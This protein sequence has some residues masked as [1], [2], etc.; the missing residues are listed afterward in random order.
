MTKVSFAAA[1]LLAACSKPAQD[2]APAG[3]KPEIAI[4]N[5]W[6]RPTVGGQSVT[7]AYLTIANFGTG[8]DRLMSVEADS[9]MSASLH[10]SS[11]DGGIARMRPITG[12][13]AIPGRR[14]VSLSPGGDHLM[15]TGL[16]EALAPGETLLL[17]LNFEKSGKLPVRFQVLAEE[18][19]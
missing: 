7:A 12:G 11:I 10:S 13:L 15:I 16:P 14:P 4:A 1:F 2:P 19:R 17:T 18:K 9:P 3:A 6:A 8:H 5:P